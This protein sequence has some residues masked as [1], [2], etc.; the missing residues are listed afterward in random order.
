MWFIRTLEKTF[1]K[2]NIDRIRGHSIRILPSGIELKRIFKEYSYT[3]TIHGIKYLADSKTRLEQ[4]WWILALIGSIIA[5]EIFIG[6]IYNKWHRSPV[7][8]SFENKRWPVVN[9]PLPAVTI[10]PQVKN[11]QRHFN[12][13]D[14]L[15]DFRNGIDIDE[16]Y[17]STEY[18]DLKEVLKLICPRCEILQQDMQNSNPYYSINVYD[19]IR[20]LAPPKSTTIVACGVENF[21]QKNCT[22]LFQRVISENGLCYTFNALSPHQL[23]RDDM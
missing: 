1:L 16:K 22:R 4:V 8:V 2:K 3:S 20:N 21:V 18:T 11:Q 23:Y 12:F 9:L 7:I 17:A 14:L 13:S 10:C 19:S 6:N 5:C 15:D